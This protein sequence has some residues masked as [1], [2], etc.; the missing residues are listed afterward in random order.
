MDCKLFERDG[1][2]CKLLRSRWFKSAAFATDI[3]A[4]FRN[5]GIGE[6]DKI[7]DMFG[8][9]RRAGDILLIST[10]NS[11]KFFKMYS[12]KGTGL[13]NQFAS[14]AECYGY[15]LKKLKEERCTF[16]VVKS[17]SSSKFG[18]MQQGTYQFWNT[19][20]CTYEELHEI[21]E[22]DREYV[23]GI[24]S[25]LDKF[26]EHIGESDLEDDWCI[27][28]LLMATHPDIFKTKLFREWRGRVIEQYVKNLR[29]GK[30]K[31]LDADYTWIVGNPMEMLQHAI[32]QHIK[33]PKKR[34]IKQYLFDKEVYCSKYEDG[35]ELAGFRNP[36]ICSGNVCLVKNTR[37]IDFI[38]YFKFGDNV[39]I[40]N[41]IGNDIMA[42]YSGCDQD[43]DVCCL[44]PD[45][46]VVELARKCAEDYATPINA[47]EGDPMYQTLT[48]RNISNVDHQIDDNQI[49]R[50]VNKSQEYNSYYWR[51][52]HGEKQQDVLDEFYRIISILSSLSQIEIDKAKKLFKMS[53]PYNKF[54]KN[55]K[56]NAPEKS[57]SI[58]VRKRKLYPDQ[59]QWLEDNG[60]SLDDLNDYLNLYEEIKG[61]ENHT[62]DE[63]VHIDS[64]SK[65]FSDINLH[66]R[67]SFFAK[68]KNCNRD[69]I[70]FMEFN[71]PMNWLLDIIIGIP[72][73]NRG[74]NSIPISKVMVKRK[75]AT[76]KHRIIYEQIVPLAEEYYDKIRVELLADRYSR[77]YDKINMFKEDFRAALLDKNIDFDTIY[78]IIRYC[79]D[80]NPQGDK[81]IIRKVKM[82]LLKGLVRCYRE[83]VKDCFI[84]KQDELVA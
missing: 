1:T 18:N 54:M 76:D 83:S 44:I 29:R 53:K 82:F 48:A 65:F 59:E 41:N 72:R 57:K 80:D 61:K 19:L 55:I 24:R 62:D 28:D 17:E 25:D 52:Y 40:H 67:P 73:A 15:W 71:T 66:V 45:K 10:P 21:C 75:L 49:G 46:K 5:S 27:M 64:Y 11:L 42:R 36:H 34:E 63:K 60:I 12:D 22:F 32:Q 30:I 7:E 51:E 8:N 2:S 39:V 33:D 50:I 37:N 9:K 3:Q 4:F 43:S 84:P 70:H 77:D 6:N 26:R 35:Q 69:G 58:E 20:P 79:Y 23:Y 78:N 68:L 38:E 56:E 16:G 13:S 81:T 47:I 74:E 31:M 14:K